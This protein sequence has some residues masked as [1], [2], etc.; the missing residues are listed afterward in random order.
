MDTV[1]IADPTIVAPVQAVAAILSP[2]AKNVQS[3]TTAEEDRKTQGQRHIN[4]IW[5]VTQAL[6]AVMIT[7][8]VIW[9]VVYGKSSELLASAFGMIVGMY[10]QRTN[11]TKTGGVG[12]T[13]SR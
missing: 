3:A 10:F 2:D 1:K 13:D 12:G 5:E 8:A 11:H 4:L 9:S 6:I 7:G